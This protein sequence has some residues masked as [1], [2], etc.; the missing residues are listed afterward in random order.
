MNPKPAR[1]EGVLR[2]VQDC[3][4][5]CT[6]AGVIGIRGRPPCRCAD[7]LGPAESCGKPEMRVTM[8]LT[9]EELAN[10]AGCSRETV[11][12]TLGRFKREQLI[13]MR[14]VS[15]HILSPRRLQRVSA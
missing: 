4:F 6:T 8:A 2:G 7:G 15:I 14:G 9:H 5:R 3:I 1:G 11:T 10:L 12:R 13:K